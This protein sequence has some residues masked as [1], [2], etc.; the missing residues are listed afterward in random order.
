MRA[1]SLQAAEKRDLTPMP[2]D[3]SRIQASLKQRFELNA[4]LQHL[5]RKE[6]IAAKI[7]PLAAKATYEVVYRGRFDHCLTNCTPAIPQR[8]EIPKPP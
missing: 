1:P 4:V 8:R 6:A 5:I 2:D 7:R 3:K